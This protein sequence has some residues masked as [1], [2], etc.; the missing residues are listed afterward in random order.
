MAKRKAD[1]ESDCI[2]HSELMTQVRQARKEG[3]FLKAVEMSVS[4]WEYV[5]GMMQYERRYGGKTEYKSID[6][7]DFVLRFAPLIFEFKSLEQLAVLLKSQ[8]RIDKNTCTDLAE[9]LDAAKSLM[10]DAHRMWRHLELHDQARQDELRSHLGGDQD[11]WRWI[12]GTWEEMGLIKRTPCG[13]SYQLAFSSRLEEKVRGKCP[14]CGATGS[15][16]KTRLLEEITC[17]KCKTNVHF[18]FLLAESAQT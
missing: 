16:V 12:A 7:I 10:W 1:L 5:D 2:L 13:G 3:D 15:G 11:R 14:S 6:S 8:R 9:Q 4:A 17:P 18:V